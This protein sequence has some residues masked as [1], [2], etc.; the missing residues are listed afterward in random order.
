VLLVRSYAVAAVLAT[1]RAP[2]SDL[3]P[4]ALRSAEQGM[5]RPSTQYLTCTLL[6]PHGCVWCVGVINVG[7]GGDNDGV[8]HGCLRAESRL[9]SQVWLEAENM[10]EMADLNTDDGAIDFNAYVWNGCA[11]DDSDRAPMF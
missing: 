11:A 5:L 2:P 7:G 9:R 3:D 6:W 4:Q 8:M 10:F 1:L